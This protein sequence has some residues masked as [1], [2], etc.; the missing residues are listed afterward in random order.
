MRRFLSALILLATL[1]AVQPAAFGAASVETY[2]TWIQ[3][4]KAAERGPFSRLRW[5]CEDGTVLPP[6]PYACSEHGG[7]HQ[8]GEWSE[9]TEE[10]RANGY[11]I[12]NILAGL[13]GAEWVGAA[14]FRDRYGQLIVE[15]FL[16]GADNGWILRRALFY[17]GAIQAEDEHEG[18]RELLV[19]MAED[20]YWS[21]PGFSAWR[22]GAK[23][24]PHGQGSASI[25]RVRQS[26]ASLADRDPGF[27]ELRAKIHGAPDAGDAERVRAY[28]AKLE[29]GERQPYEALAAEIDAVYAAASLSEILGD[30]LERGPPTPFAEPVREAQQAASGATAPMDR[31]QVSAQLLADLRSAMSD[32]R[33]AGWR[34]AALDLSLPVE[35]EFFR[36][37]TDLRKQLDGLSRADH[38]AALE[39]AGNAA[40]GAGL[41]NDRLRGE[42]LR[43]LA[44]L[45]AGTIPLADYRAVIS[46]LGR[47]PGWGT[48]ALRMNFFGAMQKLAEIEPIAMRFIQDQ[49]RAS[50]LLL[51]ADVLDALSRDAGQLA[52]VRHQIFG[53]DAGA[54]FTAL[55]PG[56]ARG[57]LHV[58]T[59]LADVESFRPDGIYVLPETVSDLPP[60]SGI[61]TAGEG[62]PLSH[63][64]LL[65][66]NL[67]IPNAT[68]GENWLPTLKENEGRSVVLAVSRSGL[69]RLAADGPEWDARLG[70][71]D[72]DAGG[73]MI[74]PDLE[75][76]DLEVQ[77]FLPL[78]ELAAA[79]SGRTVGPKAAKLGELR[80]HY[81]EAVSNGLAIPFGIFREVALERPHPDG[82]TIF[83]WMQR[84]YR[85]LG[86]I[87]TSDEEQ[88]RRYE[89][90]RAELYDLILNTPLDDGFR[91]RLES[92]LTGV[93]GAGEVPGLFV[94][95]DT[96]VEDLAGFTGAG[97]NLT[98]PN[99]VG[100]DDLLAGIRKVWASP[101]TA[102]AFAW[103]Q[104]HM[105]EPEH[106]YTSILLLES[107]GSDKSGVLVTQDIDSGDRGVLSVAVNEGLGGAVDG[108]AAESLRIDKATGEVRVL[109]T[110]TAPLR[111]VPDPA[112]GLD[113][114]P[115]SGSDT[116]LQPEEISRL[117]ELADSLPERFPPIVDDQGNPAPADIEFGFV[118]GRL[119]L[120]QLRPFLES[121]NARGSQYLAEMDATLADTRDTRVNMEQP[122]R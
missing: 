73:A 101:F 107:V 19:T 7:G 56:L 10:L 42:L 82:G 62:N 116:V 114:L 74:R 64:Q 92:A 8:H 100:M 11:Y 94:R 39:A 41:I 50:S 109:A 57:V 44:K 9:R 96:N 84:S 79:D 31:L 17:R 117:I 108:Q 69:V 99:V 81:P 120:F 6:Q 53:E 95:S 33:D 75:K 15:R 68:I 43:S 61:L 93:F 90:F 16:I 121:R 85:E 78:D 2:R 106:V 36:A 29:P 65:A 103:R 26:S 105:A 51:Y 66:R 63:V 30:F 22:T 88:A 77:R 23:L 111:R 48:Q 80:R 20:P 104:S 71:D 4:M 113:Y 115:A 28:A 122:P 55:N 59:D 37:A 24:L 49:L 52:G 72:S 110:A 60:V 58:A 46:Y 86:P 54:A 91:K 76:L 5:F 40:Y 34:L 21:G 89:A 112:G 27:R 1:T 45:D 13:D 83:E 67:G 119:Q 3:E 102:R 98:L 70:G 25:D 87:D 12:A 97:L 32:V 38:A 118:D 14:D 35:N 18:A 47:A